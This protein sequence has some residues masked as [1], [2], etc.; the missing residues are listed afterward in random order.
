MPI[1]EFAC[2][3]CGHQFEQLIIHST[4]AECPACKG[5]DLERLVSM[6]AVDSEGTRGAARKDGQQRRAQ[7]TREHNDAEIAYHKK[8][9]DHLRLVVGS[10]WRQP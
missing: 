10:W 7:L 4:T 6:F 1:Y 5:R 9:D 8:H 3:G 2:R